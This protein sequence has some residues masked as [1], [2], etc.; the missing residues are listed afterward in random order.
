MGFV[1]GFS[2]EHRPEPMSWKELL[3]S[4]VKYAELHGDRVA[5]REA[6]SGEVVVLIHGMA[7]SSETWEAVLPRLAR[8]YRVIAPDLLGHGHSDKPRT[9]YSLAAFAAGCEIS[10]TGWGSAGRPSWVTRWAAGSRCSL[11]I[12]IPSA[13]SA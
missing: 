6:G 4:D 8:N 13:A 10:L 7:G 3:M 11:C 9:D 1:G 2:G 12:N 5:Y